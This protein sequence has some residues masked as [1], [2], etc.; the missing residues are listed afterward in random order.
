MEFNLPF[1]PPQAS[2]FAPENDLLALVLIGLGVIFA[3]GVA[4]LIT[5]FAI[6]YRRGANVDRSHPPHTSLLLEVSWI[7]IPL[8]IALGVFVW[9]TDMYFEMMRPPE[10]ALDV[11]VIGK[12]WMWKI[13]HASG[14]REINQ[15]HVPTGRPV[16]L[17][18]T[19]Q[20]V[21]HSFFIPAFR[22]KYDVLPGRF[23]S[24]WFEATEPGE[25][26]L[27]C[28]EYCG[29]EHARM[30]G[31]VIAMAP[32]DYE[33]WLAANNPPNVA[34]RVL[35]GTETDTAQDDVALEGLA[36]AGQELFVDLGCSSCHLPGGEGVGPSLVGIYGE[37]R[38]LEDG[39]TVTADEE[40]IRRSIVEPNAQIVAGYPSVMPTYEGQ[41]DEEQIIALVEYIRALGTIDEG[42]EGE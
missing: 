20:D 42:T 25:Y 32:A 28:T 3:G 29:S 5:F 24:V 34:G 30:I 27:F 38:Q 12:Q 17:T 13:Q 26:H 21:I 40:Y 37:P 39:G 33:A 14:A 4:V 36:A 22:I 18:M 7:V 11:Y 16:R 31:S 35:G 41:V 15:L 8:A 19:S 23:T 9:A 1:F 2:T 10:G 6:R